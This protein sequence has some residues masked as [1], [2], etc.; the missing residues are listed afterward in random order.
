VDNRIDARK[1][2]VY[3]NVGIMWIPA[4]LNN[5]KTNKVAKEI[6]TKQLRKKY[7]VPLP[8]LKRAI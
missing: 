3:V 1:K 4:Y 8:R 7:K 5:E 6:H 2:S